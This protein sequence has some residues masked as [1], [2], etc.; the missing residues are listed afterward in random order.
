M[1]RS[2]DGREEVPY[3]WTQRPLV[4]TLYSTGHHHHRFVIILFLFL[5]LGLSK[6]AQS[7]RDVS[8]QWKKCVGCVFISSFWEVKKRSLSGKFCLWAEI[9]NAVISE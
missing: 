2:V 4:I 1:T 5:I 7:K 9:D 8:S 3:P 6:S